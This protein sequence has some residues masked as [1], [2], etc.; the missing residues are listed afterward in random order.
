MSRVWLIGWHHFRQEVTKR[1]FLLVLL[2]LPLFLLLTIGLGV[3]SVKLSAEEM[4]V[5]YVDPAQFLQDTTITVMEGEVQLVRY[6][7]AAAARTALE[8]GVITGYYVLS[9]DFPAN[10]QVELV[11]LTP[12]PWQAQNAFTTLVQQ[13][14]LADETVAVRQRVLEGPTVA[15][16]VTASGRVFPTAGPT[17][18]MFLPLLVAVTIGF[19]VMT[20]TGYMMEVVVTEKENRTM[21]ILVASLS[22]GKIMFGK[23]IGALGIAAVQL[24]VW[25]LCFALAVWL[26]R[27]P[28]D[29]TWMQTLHPDW[30]DIGLILL[31]GGP[32]YLFMAALM[33]AIGSTLVDSQDAQQAGPFYL[34][35]LYIPFFFLGAI[36]E[37]PH[38]PIALAL[39]FFPPTAL[40]AFAVRLIFDAI[41]TWQ[42]VVS[43][44]VSL[45]GGGGMI[46]LAGKV[47]R[48]SLLQYGQRLRWR[49]LFR[50]VRAGEPTRPTIAGGRQTS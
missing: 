32:V 38:G 7:D 33:T 10:P 36:A 34:L 6:D 48:L 12:P 47:F 24:V 9:P 39:S 23:I 17:L 30:G 11:Y 22:T 42:V 5:G 19:L 26:G 18:A 25:S 50:A 13:N 31:I 29:I 20:S 49:E 4:A 45:V 40:T 41:P 35:I 28:L 37:S 16:R 2:S 43:V 15:V 46:W 21:E 3:L 27:G 44:M 8:S 1:S 14:L